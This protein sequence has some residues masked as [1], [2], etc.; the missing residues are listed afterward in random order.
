MVANWRDLSQVLDQDYRERDRSGVPRAAVAAVFRPAGSPDGPHHGHDAELL[1]IQRA[2]R[3]SDPWSGQM[4]FPGGRKDPV[5][6][7]PQATAM[8]ETEEEVGLDLSPARYLGSL[9]EL[10]GGRATNRRVIVSAHAYWLDGPRPDLTPNYEVADTVWV[11]LRHLGDAERYID[12]H[13]AMAGAL[14]PGIQLD[15]R[16]QVIWGLT[17]RFLSDLFDRLDRPFI[18]D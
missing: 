9:S 15:R 1:F 18:T 17:L 13:Y 12:Y 6:P 2:T 14:F 5:D 4:A 8:R 16:N 7:T 11:P 3:E 10:D